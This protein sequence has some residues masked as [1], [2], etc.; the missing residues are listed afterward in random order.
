MGHAWQHRMAARRLQELI[1]SA[2]NRFALS[3]CAAWCLLD[4][5]TCCDSRG[6]LQLGV[7]RRAEEMEGRLKKFPLAPPSL[8]CDRADRGSWVAVREGKFGCLACSA[9]P[10]PI[11]GST[12]GFSEFKISRF[13]SSN[14]LRHQES[15]SHKSAVLATLGLH[16]LQG[17]FNAGP[18]EASLSLIAQRGCI[19]SAGTSGE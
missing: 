17:I 14:F 4:Y 10:Q 1:A 8:G 3:P 19:C 18:P 5:A 16:P 13:V 2:L 11:V 6:G 15:E 12:K 7:F 9:H